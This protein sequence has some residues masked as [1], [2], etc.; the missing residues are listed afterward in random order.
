[1]VTVKNK[2]GRE[3]TLLNPS[4]KGGKFAKEL[5]QGVKRTNKGSFKLDKNKKSI[6][7]TESERAYRAGY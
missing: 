1:M 2:K 4:E 6:K 7:L 5:K 3:V